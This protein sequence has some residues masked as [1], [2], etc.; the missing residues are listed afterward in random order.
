MKFKNKAKLILFVLAI[1]ITGCTVEV[2]GC[3]QLEQVDQ[4]GHDIYER[5]EFLEGW[6]MQEANFSRQWSDSLWE[7]FG[8]LRTLVLEDIHLR[9]TALEVDMELQGEDWQAAI[10]SYMRNRGRIEQ[11]EQSMRAIA[12]AVDGYH[13][14][15]CDDMIAIFGACGIR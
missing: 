6:V 10:T 12:W 8:G 2:V 9:V 11:L 7:E 15:D 5:V 13:H 1:A 3:D 4:A 14:L